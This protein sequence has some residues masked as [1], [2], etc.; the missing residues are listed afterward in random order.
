MDNIKNDDYYVAKLVADISF[1]V[2]H[3]KNVDA[4]ELNENELLLDSFNNDE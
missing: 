4:E 1:I 2:K 3:M